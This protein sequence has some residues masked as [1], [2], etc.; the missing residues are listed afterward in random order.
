M[1]TAWIAVG[2]TTTEDSDERVIE[3]PHDD[4]VRSDRSRTAGGSRLRRLRRPDGERRAGRHALLGLHGFQ[5]RPPRPGRQW[6]HRAVRDRAGVRRSRRPDRGG[7]WIRVGVRDL[8][9]RR[10]CP[11]GGGTRTRNHQA[12]PLRAAIRPGGRTPPPGRHCRHVHRARRGRPTRRSGRVLHG[13]GGRPAA[14]VRRRRAN[15]AVLGGPGSDRAH[16]RI[17]RHD[18]GR[19]PAESRRVRRDEDSDSSAGRRRELPVAGRHGATARRCPPK[20][21]GRDAR[22][23]TAQ[24]G[25]QRARARPGGIL[26]VGLMRRLIAMEYVTV[27]GIT[28]AP[29]HAGEDPEGGFAYGGWTGPFLEDH[30]RYMREALNAM[31]ALVLGRITYEIWAQYWPTVTDPGDEIARMLN[32]VPKYVASTAMRDGVWSETTVI[33]D[34]P[35]QVRELKQEPGK[36]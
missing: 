23:A 22:G 10:S 11:E 9:R 8:V 28:Q 17:R 13:R 15:A 4:R 27:D 3:R 24:R 14:R 35:R 20:R 21:T 34:V 16:A 33:D 2:T 29:G 18:H 25:R 32:T 6:R 5:L 7:R 1:R 36:D 31:G 30:R 12:R 26:R 19:L